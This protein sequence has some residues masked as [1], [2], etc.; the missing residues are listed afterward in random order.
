MTLN[1]SSDYTW[2]SHISHNTP[3][4][5]KASRR[6]FLID[7]QAYYTGTVESVEGCH[8]IL[9]VSHSAIDDQRQPQEE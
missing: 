7:P 6:V 3:W 8:Y 5:V 4:P 1:M 2:R 9:C